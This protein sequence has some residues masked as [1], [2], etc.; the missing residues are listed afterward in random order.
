MANIDIRKHIRNNFKKA[1]MED[2][3]NS[4]NSSIKSKDEVIL[5]GLGVFFEILWENCEEEKKDYILSTLMNN[6]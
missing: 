4:I 1:S 2:I 3:E 6:I 5:P